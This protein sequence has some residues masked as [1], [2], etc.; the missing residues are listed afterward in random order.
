MQTYNITEEIKETILKECEKTYGKVFAA[1]IYG[2]QVCGYAREG[3]DFD[4]LVI[5]DNYEKGVKYT[6]IR[7]D[8]EIAFLAVDKPVFENDIHNAKYGDFIAGRILNPI[9]PLINQEYFF[10]M[11]TELKKRII[12]WEIKR[13]IYK[14]GEDAK[15]IE[16]NLLY[17]PFR[18]WNKL[19][20][21][22]RP[23]LY[24]I[25]STLRCD[26]RQRNLN[27]ILKNYKRAVNELKILHEIYPG[28]YKIDENFIKEVLKEP[29]LFERIKIREREIEQV[30]ARYMTHKKAGNSDRDIF[31]EEITSKVTR[32]VKHIK[33]VG[34]KHLLDDSGKYINVVPRR[35]E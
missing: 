15:F 13:I 25:E 1:A 19:A 27:I 9:L 24:S 29:A 18:K 5:L 26:L 4:V 2:S 16:I 22:Y 21:I 34:F 32:E 7:N 17:F 8:F 28:W 35:R 12:E 20:K 23:Y 33:E 3:S 30:I 6:Y 10:D 11:E 31:I 14:H